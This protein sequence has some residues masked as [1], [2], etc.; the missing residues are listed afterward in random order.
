MTHL[1]RESTPS[2][3][4]SNVSGWLISA[5]RAWHP[6][7][8]SSNVSG[9]LISIERAWHPVTNSSNV[10][11]RLISTES[12][13]SCNSSNVSGWLMLCRESMA[14]CNKQFK[15]L[16]MTHLYRESMASHNKQFKCL[17]DDSSLQR[18]RHPV[19]NSSVSEM[20]HLCRESMAS[21]NKQ[22][23][24]LQDDSC[25]CSRDARHPVDIWTVCYRMPCSLSVE[26]SMASCRHLN[27]SNVYR[28]THVSAIERAW[29]IL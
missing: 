22:F 21:C 5:E 12:T 29:V 14:S 28:M 16:R 3:N 7:T 2:C 27:C 8:N 18:A 13:A 20:T 9:W 25:L 15:C 11:G 19:T 26:M 4:S 1:C 17:Q 24:C 10:S 6:V 23:K